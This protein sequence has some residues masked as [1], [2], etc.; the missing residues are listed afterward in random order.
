MIHPLLSFSPQNFGP[1][2]TSGFPRRGFL[3][4]LAGATAAAGFFEGAA[5]AAQASMSKLAGIDAATPEAEYWTKVRSEFMVTDELA[6]MNNG[7]LGPM[8]KPVFYSV[9]ENYR[10]LAADPAAP[11]TAMSRQA[12]D[13]RKKAADFLGGGVEEIALTRNTT[14]GMNFIANGLDMKAGDEV[15]TTFHEHSGGLQP[16]KLKAKRHGVVL[17]ELKFQLPVQDPA[18]LLNMFN[19]AITPRTKVIS[20]CHITYQTGTGMPVKELASLARSKGILTLVDAAHP[21]GMMKLDLHDLGID[22][23]AMSPHKWLDA[24]TGTGVLYMR[25]ES[26][27]RVWPTMG[28]TGWDDPKFGAKRFDRLSQRSWPLVMAQGVAMDFQMAI[29]RE[30]IE[31]RVRSLQ[32]LLRKRLEAI[33]GVKIHTSAHPALHCALLG[34]TLDGLKNADIVETLLKRHHIRVRTMEYGLNAVRASTHY[35]NTEA[36]VDRLADGIE[37]VFKRGVIPAPPSPTG[38]DE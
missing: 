21:L 19:E 24:P 30:K 11:N 37:D 8:P 16:W 23:Y 2:E 22:Y 4:G 13:V 32:T 5:E 36:Q 33:P 17:K 18:A 20:F 10:A 34:F 15:L 38:G 1:P 31:T 27:D 6:F 25:R 35:Y 28:S 3:R 29:G 12:E 14:E 9:V 7:T 26:Q